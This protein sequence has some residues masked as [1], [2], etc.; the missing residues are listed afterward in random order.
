[1]P[2]LV[3][4]TIKPTSGDTVTFS[5]CNVSIGGTLTY[6]DVTNVDSVGIVTA[7]SGI[8]VLSGVVTAMAGAAVTYYGDGSNLTGVQSG[9][10]NFVASG[11]IDNGAA[12]I[13]NTDGTVGIVTLT[14]SDT[15]EAGTP[16]FYDSPNSLYYNAVAYDSTNDKV[17]IAYADNSNSLKGK[18]IVGTVSG[19]S[20]SFGT[21]V[22]FESGATDYPRVTFVGS[23]KV[24]IA[25]RDDDN[26]AYG[27][28][29]VGTVSGT[30]ISFGTPVVFESAIINDSSI[31]YDSTNDR[32]VITYKDQGN[33]NYGTAIVGTVSGTSISFG[34]AVVFESAA[35]TTTS[36]VFDTTNDKVVI[37]YQDAINSEYGTAIVGTVSGT[38]ISFGTAAVFESATTTVVQAAYVGSGKVVIAY[39]DY[40]NS[41]YGTAVV[42]TVSGTSISYGTPVVFNSANSTFITVSY[43]ST[44]DK[45]VISYRD[46][47]NSSYGTSI[48]GTVSG[49]SISF[50]TPVV[51]ESD[52]IGYTSSAY[53]PDNGKTVIVYRSSSK[54]TA[55]VLS[56]T[57]SATNLTAENYI[58]IAG[59]AIANAATGK[60][61]VLGG[62]NSGQS[63]LTT[64]KKYYV[65]QTGILTTT[66]DTPS[67]VAGTS[68]SDTKIL[69][70]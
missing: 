66:A 16:V 61:T 52:T 58:G 32:V 22:E 2:T 55:V 10:K 68:I 8:K 67:V 48:L 53:D 23:G 30:S 24:V 54:G 9:V 70:R 4:N 29:V 41:D 34:T 45:V 56:S 36:A 21:A 13:L 17:V 59:E 37:A 40:G 28:A 6:E 46:W 7:R 57:S 39:R 50:G 33:N 25:Y 64:A 47:G 65:G 63:G 19:S 60:V 20:I 26:N 12:V 51:F 5:D 44:N 35:S 31:T 38:S 27:T 15:P 43:D 14:T 1:M 69:V 11:A 18:A 42:G 49:T 3:A 62:V